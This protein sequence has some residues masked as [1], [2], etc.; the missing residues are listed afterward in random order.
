MKNSFSVKKYEFV[1]HGGWQKTIFILNNIKCFYK[2]LILCD[3]E[4]PG[5]EIYGLIVDSL[6]WS[7]SRCRIKNVAIDLIGI[8]IHNFYAVDVK[9]NFIIH[10]FN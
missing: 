7:M 3:F 1:I 8:A 4:F 10:I 9:L 6:G 2:N 5:N